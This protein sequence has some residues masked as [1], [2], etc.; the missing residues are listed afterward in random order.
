MI[1]TDPRWSCLVNVI[2]TQEFSILSNK[3]IENSLIMF[4]V[5]KA[6]NIVTLA[7]QY[8]QDQLRKFVMLGFL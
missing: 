2:K 1:S 3:P 4:E 7:S 6:I 5:A 8:V